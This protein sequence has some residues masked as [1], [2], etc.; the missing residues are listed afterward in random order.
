M[1]DTKKPRPGEL[2]DA[3]LAD[4]R[5]EFLSWRPTWAQYQEWLRERGWVGAGRANDRARGTKEGGKIG[6]KH[7]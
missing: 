2:T 5:A 1:T 7:R 6:R 4:W 3:E